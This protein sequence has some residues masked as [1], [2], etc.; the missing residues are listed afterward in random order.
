LDAKGV[1][2]LPL[3]VVWEESHPM[4]TSMIF[5]EDGLTLQGHTCPIERLTIAS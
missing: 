1:E 4:H 5:R 3:M 2:P